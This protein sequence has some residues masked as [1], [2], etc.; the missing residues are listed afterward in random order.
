[1]K[2][3]FFMLVLFVGTV[4]VHAN[5]APGKTDY[6][7]LWA[8]T[9]S[10]AGKGLT[11]SALDQVQIIYT[12]AQNEKN[13]PQFV[14]A[15]IYRIKLEANVKE[16]FY[17]ST[18]SRL[19]LEVKTSVY[20]I[21]PILHSVLAEMYWRYYQTNRSLF[22]DRTETFNFKQDDIAT[23]DLNKIVRETIKNFM[24]SI[25]NAD[26]LKK[27][28]L[29]RFDDI[30]DTQPDSKKFRPTLYDFLAH[31]V[32]D[33]FKNEE[34][35]L[36]KPAYKFEIS[37][38][39]Y[40]LPYDK[41]VKETL[42]TKDTLSLKFYALSIMQ[43]LLKFHQFDKNPEALVEV[44][45][46]RLEFVKSKAVFENKDSLYLNSLLELENK[47]KN[48]PSST[49]ISY[50]IAGYYS[51]KGADY[52]P[53][54]GDENKWMNKKAI[55][56][57]DDAIKRFPNSDGAVN[58]KNLS[59]S[60]R[61][62]SI[63]FTTEAI[64]LPDKPFRA[65][66]SYK[67]ISTLYLRVISANPDE[68]KKQRYYSTDEQQMKDYIAAKPFKEWTVQLPDDGDF[69]NHA[70]EIKIP[71]LPAGFYTIL[72]A[73]DKNFVYQKEA[74]AYSNTWTSNISYISRK[75]EDGAY[76][77][78]VLDREK[79]TPLKQVS[80][81]LYIEKYDYTSRQYLYEKSG[82]YATN[83]EGYFEI[84]KSNSDYSYFFIDF[85]YQKDRLF[86]D[87]NFY[88]YKYYDY[89][90]NKKEIT[91]TF[92]A[93]RAIYRPGQTLYFKGIVLETDRD[94]KTT[95][96]K[97]NY[98]TT[99]VLYDV[100]NQK[101]SELKLTTNEY[102]TFNG[103]FT[104][105]S[106]SLN[107]Q[108]YLTNTYGSL[109][110][111]V[112]EYKRPKFE[113]TIDPVKGSYKLGETITVKGN[114]KAYAGSVIDDA[115]VKYR[116]VRTATFPYWWY[117]WRGYY[118][119]SPQMEITNGYAKTNEKGEFTV[120]FTAIPDPT[121]SKISDPKF[122]YTV[123]I[124]VTDIN[125]ES[126][127]AQKNVYVAYKALWASLDIYG[128]VNKNEEKKY[129]INT[130]NTNGE[131]EYAKGNI[132]VYKLKQPERL[133][134][135]RMWE[136]A[137]KHLLT[138]EE[139]YTAFPND[140]FDDEDNM[141]KWE[142]GNKV[143]ETEFDTQKD[144][145]LKFSKISSWES[146]KYVLELKT[147]D[148][149][150][151]DVQ[152]FSY[153]TVFSPDEKICPSNDIDWFSNIKSDCEPGEKASFVIGTKEKDVTMLYEIESK[154]EII[155]KQWLKLSNEQKKIEIPIM[156]DYRGNISA[157]FSFVKNNR[158]YQ[159]D[160]EV[161]VPYTNK[162]LDL[163]FSTFRDKLNPGQKE[164]WKMTIKGKKGDKVA[165]ELLAGMYDAS[166]DAFKSNSWYLNVFNSFYSQLSWN[167]ND[168]FTSKGSTLFALDWNVYPEYHYQYYDQL[169]WFGF[170]YYGDY[171]NGSYGDEA[172]YS[173]P[174]KGNFRANTRI[175]NALP[176]M[177]VLEQKQQA[178]GEASGKDKTKMAGLKNGDVAGDATTISDGNIAGEKDRDF[179]GPGAEMAL[180]KARSN[181]N[182]TAFFFPNLQTDA[183]GNVVISFTVPEALTK[184]KFMGLAHTKDLKTGMIEKT[185]V[186]QKDL[187][188]MPNAPRF[189]REGDKIT[190]SSK[191]SNLADKDL[192]GD[193]Q[194]FLFD[195]ST[196]KP[197][198]DLLNNTN[199]AK[200]FDAK[201]GQ[202]TALNWD[203][204]IP[205]GFGAITYK[206]VAKAGNFSDGE[207]MAV[208]VLTNR[209]L[210]T[211]TM[212]LP[213]R[214]K[215]TKEFSFIKLL[216]SKSSTT[217]RNHKLTLEFSSNP[218]WYAIQALPYLM[219]YP[220][221][222]AEQTFDRFYANSIASNIANSSPK[223]KAVFDSWKNFT[224]DALLSNL[225]KNQDLKSL[226]LEE[227]PW[228][229]DAK[230]ENER[231]QRV[232]LL[233]DLN[234]MGNELDKTMRKLQAMQSSNGGFPWFA[235]MPDDRYITQY[236]V[237]G[238]GH[239]NKLG[240][241]D[242]SKESKTLNMITSAMLYLDN[243]IK[244]D[245]DYIKKW[246]PKDMDK[247]HLDGTQ[248]Q[249]LYARSYFN[250]KIEISSSNKEA[251]DYFK[252][253]AKKFWTEDSRY[254][255]G[256][257]ATALNRYGD[258][259]TAM[260]IIKSLKEN[261]LHSEEM[262]M[263][264]KDMDAGYYWWQAPIETQALLIE[265]FDEVANDQV[266]VEELKVWL[267]KQ[268]QT[269]DWKTTKATADACYALLLKGTQWLASDQ[270]VEI[271]MGDQ[272][273]DPKKMD[274]VKIEAGTGYFKTSWSGSDIK[275]E[276][277][278]VTVTKKD[279]GVA[280]GA[281][282][283]QYFE[284]LDKITPAAT[285]LKLE[286]KLF[287]ERNTE[288]GPQIE[289]VTENT[290]IKLGDK[291]KVRIELRVDRDM[292]YVH[293]KDMR[294]SGFEPVNVISDYKYQ[295]GLGYYESTRDASTNFF[296]SYLAKGT[297]V[298]EYALKATMKGD[299]SNGVTTIQCMYAPEFTSHSEGI[300]VKIGE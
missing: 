240:V 39:N 184:W 290:K 41:F 220:Y 136:R 258:K 18:I 96:I 244:E 205:E 8:K 101:V 141:Y 108:M 260:D 239:L 226:M 225:E 123:Y 241:L 197:I 44:E 183:D 61:A 279:E 157:H 60:I 165:A 85:Q 196:M 93:D 160:A 285:P 142:K 181:F 30:I 121:V 139:Y 53:L 122:N 32:I 148:K 79:G 182:E 232:A 235:G 73:T 49:K 212:P 115:E 289:P 57:C 7:K 277:G 245:Y 253:Q 25:D 143:F 169:N 22:K 230:S 261:A 300:R 137:D 250:D 189:F 204:T 227:T 64:N 110:F 152:A 21:K 47:F 223:I 202:S 117:W 105:P 23:W 154:G 263:Y 221:E 172:A 199:A 103:T 207:E 27:A 106:G 195:A 97:P 175:A 276:M 178:P 264:W 151:Q 28:P 76:D 124:D 91:T 295:G 228:V 102:G 208:P 55:T 229:L 109:Y 74:I 5:A 95:I 128:D 203:L 112:E 89:D 131:Y 80:A 132:V 298:F 129:V 51:G 31:R 299:F 164:E 259:I 70:V 140:V 65:Y 4:M 281:V 69:Q 256:M 200:T 176:S 192:T 67:N 92:F 171:F 118:P 283:W 63:T 34:P 222:C 273:I 43:N 24:A 104:T 120:D 82:K 26:S 266:T 133:F 219:E 275:P 90:L 237:T 135:N 210:V 29:D 87:Q 246:Y 36:I 111:S 33:F 48:D 177:A 231:K 269:Q 113:V 127:S 174:K 56:V 158:G 188:V 159:H 215:Q 214:G 149:Y 216:N 146:G 147:K 144:S 68:Y 75:K 126:H 278:K 17:E 268:K 284:Q 248:I 167:T 62:K 153:F 156:E 162:Q 71:E 114:A 77:I 292:E 296:I 35:D 52:K 198:D 59:E 206:V 168:A 6:D 14:K 12:K 234:K 213:I 3:K 45:L 125:G 1:M 19:E 173:Y 81:Q 233:F 257:I 20:P 16:D 99:V 287:I 242:V 40:I 94:T 186:T 83:E 247:N 161:N 252:G 100:N 166:L 254:L 297:Y 163:E 218:A 243:R 267:L 150:G 217:L 46:E 211:E 291:I 66:V 251:F 2:S 294:A 255:Q 88:Q 38:S 286:K 191:I 280:W 107:G 130:T 288:T 42:S 249:Y 15:V 180:V 201:K 271:T 13:A 179:S 170:T 98:Q 78:Y 37:N 187:M 236:I 190:F 72:A 238:F 116:V 272:K 270:L 10:L 145:L 54:N 134:R 293:M 274:D 185:I 9:D 50:A 265:T 224:P 262:G 119:S 58:C 155:S 138:K 194:L 282:Y 84:P 209:M 193:A 11:A 86:S